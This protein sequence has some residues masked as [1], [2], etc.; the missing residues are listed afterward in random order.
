MESRQH[1]VFVVDFAND[2]QK[3]LDYDLTN[4]RVGQ[5]ALE[6]GDVWVPCH[7]IH[8]IVL[9]KNLQCVKTGKT[10]VY[11]DHLRIL[12]QRLVDQTSFEE[13]FDGNEKVVLFKE[14]NKALRRKLTLEFF[15]GSIYML[16]MRISVE[17]NDGGWDS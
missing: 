12:G 2:V 13:F 17:E 4:I 16:L 15:W 10:L 6:K 11:D 5:D 7:T 8:A 14:F 1:T 3:D 9:H